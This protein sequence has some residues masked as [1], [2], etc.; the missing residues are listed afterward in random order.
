MI[1]TNLSLIS[2]GCLNLGWAQVR[3]GWLTSVNIPQQT[4]GACEDYYDHHWLHPISVVII[5]VTAE[6]HPIHNDVCWKYF[7]KVEI[8]LTP[9][10]L[11]FSVWWVGRCFRGLCAGLCPIWPVSWCT[12]R[13]ERLSTTIWNQQLFEQLTKTIMFLDVIAPI[14]VLELRYYCPHYLHQVS[15]REWTWEVLYYPLRN[16]CYFYTNSNPGLM[17]FIQVKI[18]SNMIIQTPQS[19]VL[20]LRFMSKALNLIYSVKVQLAAHSLTF[21]RQFKF[22][23]P[24]CEW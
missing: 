11:I 23:D 9:S 17:N 15:S 12:G 19:N 6:R 13:C 21:T 14:Y 5:T 7:S 20:S 4:H 8:C 24:V 3:D 16:D 1:I 2:W 18:S 22:K 10:R